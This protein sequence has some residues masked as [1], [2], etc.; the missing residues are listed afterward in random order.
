MVDPFAERHPGASSF[1]YANNNPIRYI[2]P[3]G[4][5]RVESQNGDMMLRQIT[6]KMKEFFRMVRL[7][8]EHFYE[9]VSTW[10]NKKYKGAVLET[11]HTFKK[12][13]YS[14]IKDAQLEIAGQMRNSM[15][16][17]IDLTLF[18][19]LADGT[20]RDWTHKAVAGG[21]MVHQKLENIPPIP[22]EIEGEIMGII[23]RG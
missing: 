8:E 22:I 16:G 21:G 12:M 19:I 13:T 1:N 17:D 5:D 6:I 23:V 7:T 4:R 20:E 11:Y 18:L 15:I 14:P 3:D 9:R 2:D 10:N